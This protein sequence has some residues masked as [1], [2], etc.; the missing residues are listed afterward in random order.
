MTAEK[1]T[2]GNGVLYVAF[3]DSY[4][5]EVKESLAS[6][7][8]VSP[9]IKTCVITN[10]VW[11]DSPVPDT[12]IER[13]PIYSFECKP[14]YICDSP[15]TKTLFLDTDTY[16]ARDLSKVFNL[17]DYYDVGVLFGG[18]QLNES[19]IEYHLQCSSSTILFRKGDEMNKVFRQWLSIYK[20]AQ[21]IELEHDDFR[22]LGDQRY[23]SIAIAKSK[24]RPLH[25]GSHLNFILCAQSS[26][27][28]PPYVYT[29]RNV[30]YKWADHVITD[31]WNPS[32]DWWE[33]TWMANI[34]GVLPAGLRRSG[35]LL[36][37]ALL[38]RRLVN[39]IKQKI[40]LLR[41]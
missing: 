37:C 17:L 8:R 24:A 22:G 20:D 31:G 1:T 9:N 2:V 41:H 10:E 36:G 7:K 28:S 4:L 25:L 38:M 33:R 39:D 27:C 11:E 30:D 13:A 23:L 6:L 32:T 26:T 18:S 19:G 12:F 14:L 21:A 5:A 34:K 29:G 3:G 16:V 15:F 35:L 40:W